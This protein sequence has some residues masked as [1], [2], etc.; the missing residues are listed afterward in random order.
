MTICGKSVFQAFLVAPQPSVFTLIVYH[1][2][3]GME[4]YLPIAPRP[5]AALRLQGENKVGGPL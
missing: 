1:I 4:S 5:D 3:P 2:S